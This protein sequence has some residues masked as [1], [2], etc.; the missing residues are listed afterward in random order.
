L[1][2]DQYSVRRYLLD[3]GPNLESAIRAEIIARIPKNQLS[4]KVLGH[5]SS[6]PLRELFSVY[7]NWRNRFVSARPRTVY[8]SNEIA[9]KNLPEVDKLA[10]K[11]EAG[12]DLSPHLSTGIQEIIDLRPAKPG[13]LGSRRDLDLLLN[14]WGIH[15]LHL[16]EVDRGD[17]Y[18]IRTGALL[19]V[20][21]RRNDAYLLDVLAHGAWNDE[22][23]V[24]IGTSN[25]PKAGL[26]AQFARLTTEFPVSEHERKKLRG[27][28]IYAPIQLP[29]GSAFGPGLTSAGTSAMIELK[30]NKLWNSIALDEGR[31]PDSEIVDQVRKALDF[32]PFS[33]R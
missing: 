15:H 24:E 23:L 33:D 20:A 2:T 4:Q 5:L 12:G 19:F 7:Y 10:Q 22:R 8:R 6:I 3:M 17:G 31:C 21:F 14:D 30:I 9:T 1:S 28:G 13:K 27:S 26:F 32:H 18:V 11:V 16:S 29:T 25:W